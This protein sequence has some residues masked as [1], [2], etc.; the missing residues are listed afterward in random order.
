MKFLYELVKFFL[1]KRKL[2]SKQIKTEDDIKEEQEIFIYKYGPN[3]EKKMKKLKKIKK[4]I[5]KRF[6]KTRNLIKYL[7]QYSERKKYIINEENEFKYITKRTEEEKGH[8]KENDN[9]SNKF[10][11]Y[12]NNDDAPIRQYFMMILIK[13]Y[14]I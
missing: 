12:C 1:P 4:K 5:K 14:Q 7:H 11:K 13:H 2:L 8:K 6:Y 10:N 3:D 9:Y